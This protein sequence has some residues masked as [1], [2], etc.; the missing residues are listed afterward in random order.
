MVLLTKLLYKRG[1]KQNWIILIPSLGKQNE[2]KQ[3][4]G[5]STLCSFKLMKTGQNNCIEYVTHRI[6]VAFLLLKEIKRK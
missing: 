1:H 6:S 2:I 3:S 4:G 5:L